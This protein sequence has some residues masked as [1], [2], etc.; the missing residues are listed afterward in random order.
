MK[1]VQ[2]SCYILCGG[3][4]K[5]LYPVTSNQSPKYDYDLSILSKSQY[6]STTLEDAIVRSK[7]MFKDITLISKVEHELVIKKYLAKHNK[8]FAL[9]EETPRN[10]MMSVISAAKHALQKDGDDAIVVIMPSD[11]II[12]LKFMFANDINKAITHAKNFRKI[13]I[14]G[15]GNFNQDVRNFGC[16]FYNDSIDDF[17]SVSKFI[18][19]PHENLH[20]EK[21]FLNSGIFVIPAKEL[22]NHV[23]SMYS[24]IEIDF[25]GIFIKYNKN[26]PEISFDHGFLGKV[27]SKEINVLEANFDFL[28]IG[29]CKSICKKFGDKNGNV[30]IG[31]LNIKNI[32]NSYLINNSCREISVSNI[33]NTVVNVMDNGNILICGIGN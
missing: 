20:G 14:F 5:R 2:A 25:D 32:K 28:D 33:E 23:Y 17:Y 27:D 24:G 22:I 31:D 12:D 6:S 4:G 15:L 16:I 3:S 7:K 29:S 18:E 1:Y 10:T 8:L 21:I 30:V 13:V 9:F 26:S 19:K 11:Q